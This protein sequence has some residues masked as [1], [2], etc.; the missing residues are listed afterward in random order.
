MKVKTTISCECGRKY[1]SKDAYCISRHNQSKYHQE[2]LLT[3]I[4]P[5]ERKQ[6]HNENKKTYRHNY[7][8]CHKE[9]D[10]KP[11]QCECGG[12]FTNANKLTHIKTKKHQDYINLH[13]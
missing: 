5:D 11:N 6:I 4:T 8:E 9:H 1:Q 12:T 13:C 10:N 2:Y 3:G 7:Y